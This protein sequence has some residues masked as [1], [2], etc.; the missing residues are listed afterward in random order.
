[1]ATPFMPK[2]IDQALFDIDP[3]V[4][5]AIARACGRRRRHGYLRRTGTVVVS[6]PGAGIVGKTQNARAITR[7]T[8]REVTN[9]TRRFTGWEIAQ[10]T[11]DY[12]ARLGTDGGVEVGCFAGEPVRHHRSIGKSNG[13]NAFGFEGCSIWIARRAYEGTD[14][15]RKSNVVIFAAAQSWRWNMNKEVHE[16]DKS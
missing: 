6:K 5:L 8:E 15:S 4:A 11:T 9:G 2:A 3:A 10:R 13:K 1:M 12:I 7:S 16:T 14:I